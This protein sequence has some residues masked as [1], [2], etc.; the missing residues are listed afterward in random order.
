VEVEGAAYF[1]VCEG[2]TNVLKHSGCEEAVVGLHRRDRQLHLLVSDTGGGFDPR[3]R[4]LSGVRGLA[5]RIEALGGRV[6]VVSTPGAGT[7]LRAWVPIEG[8]ETGWKSR[9]GS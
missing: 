9:S 4:D 5:D 3:R 1:F 2:L 6:E 8:R 7:E